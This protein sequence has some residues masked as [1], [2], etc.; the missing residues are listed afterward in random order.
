MTTEKY[1]AEVNS[2]GR[3]LHVFTIDD[4]SV[5]DPVHDGAQVFPLVEP[6]DWAAQP[7]DTS[8]VM[9][10]DGTPIWVET[11][12][13]DDLK[14]RKND[15]INAGRMSAN[16]TTFT[17]AGKEIACDTLSRSD[18]DGTN[19]YVS[20]F[21]AFAPN[22]KG[23]WKAKDNSYVPIATVDDWKAFYSAMVQQ[24]QQNFDHAQSLKASLANATT[25]EQVAAIT[26][27]F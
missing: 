8:A 24:G 5:P 21:G 10:N 17:Y 15:E 18:I 2:T 9:W 19:G 11:A 16:L 20:L 6:I 25:P 27:Q 22:W 13:L 7:T 26:V 14:A 3:V 4:D 12:S 23:A 1:F